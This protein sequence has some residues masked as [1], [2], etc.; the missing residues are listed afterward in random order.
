MSYTLNE[1]A[2]DAF[3]RDGWIA[4]DKFVP[5]NDVTH[6]R[7]LLLGLFDGNVGFEEG[8]QFDAAGEDTD[9]KARRFP[10]ILRPS[11]YAKDLMAS[12]YFKSAEIVAKQLLGPKARFKLDI[13][14]LKPPQI[15]SDTAWH[16]D[17]AFGNPAFDQDEITIWLAVTPASSKNSCMSFIPGSHLGPVLEH[18]PVGGDP[19][20]HALECIGPFDASTAVESPLTAGSATVHTRRTLHYAGPN[21]SDDYRLAYALLFDTPPVLRADPY[22]FPW[23]QPE[24]TD[25]SERERAWKRQH[26]MLYTWRKFR[27]IPFDRIR[28][29]IYCRL[30]KLR[31]RLLQFRRK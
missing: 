13:A 20:M 6:I 5:E 9:P 18:Q 27:G 26:L 30:Q 11:S 12:E 21:S 8:A 17:E 4:M 2:V 7:T 28:I 31:V 22:F 1:Q 10:Q 14:F 24:Q 23:K 16:Q 3:H 29:E 25:R 15:G 19:R